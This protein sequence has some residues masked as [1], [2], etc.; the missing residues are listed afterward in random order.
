[1]KKFIAIIG[2]LAW[3]QHVAW[4]ANPAY[5]DAAD[6]AYGSGWLNGSN[7]GFGFGAWHLTNFGINS[8]HFIGDSTFN[9]DSLDDGNVGGAAGDGD[10]NVS[11]ANP[12]AWGLFGGFGSIAQAYRMFTGGPLSI[13][14]VFSV[15][16]DNE[17]QFMGVAG[18]A[19]IDAFSNSVMQVAYFGGL[20]NAYMYLDASTSGFITTGLDYGDE[21]L[22]LDV[23]MIGVTNYQATLTR[24]DGT[25]VSW[26]G[27]MDA[28]PEGFVAWTA[29]AFGDKTFINRMSIVPE[30][31]A[32][33]LGALGAI[34]LA[35]RA[36]RRRASGRIS[37]RKRSSIR[38]CG[39]TACAASS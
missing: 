19:L 9:G 15:Y 21:G 11:L 10:I 2:M 31:P 16:F 37:C 38:R 25:S 22:R 13:G 23:S 28:A 5:D 12:V 27:A 32:L 39:K 30:P 7:G 8:F 20:T 18:V 14:E 6:P 29:N 26:S 33:A 24:L 1:M 17:N 35:L 4:S 36:I 34:G 3:T